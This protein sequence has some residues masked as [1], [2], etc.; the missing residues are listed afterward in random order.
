MESRNKEITQ[1][2]YIEEKAEFTSAFSEVEPEAEVLTE[3]IEQIENESERAEDA[4]DT[5]EKRG[6]FIERIRKSELFTTPFKILLC[7]TLASLIVYVISRFVPTFAE[8]WTRYPAQSIRFV[9]AKLT[10]WIPFSLAETLIVSLPALA[11]AYIVGS[12]V[13]TKRDGSDKNFYRWLRPLLSVV[14]VI[15]T[16]FLS[17]FGPAYGRYTLA[18][19][20][21]LEQKAV[22]SEELF[23]TGIIVSSMANLELREVVFDLSGASV[24]PYDYNTLVDKMN[25]AFGNYAETAD[26]IGHF[27]SNPK[28]IA[29]SEPMTYTHISGV[30]TFMTGESNV[31]TNY[32]DFLI[33]FT[34]AHEMAHQRGIAREDEANF[35]AFLVCISS[36]DA[37]IRYSGYTNMLHY[38]NG[39]LS[40]AD[41]DKYAVLYRNYIPASIQKEFS[42][43]SK[44][45]DK[46]R[47]SVASEVT[48]AVNNSFL[49]SQ[50][51][52]AGTKSYGLVVD[53]AVSYY[54]AK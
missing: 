49:Q 52:Q 50:G 18:E 45:F 19:N 11:I 17:A 25:K 51:Q 48:G 54:K 34:M 36:D 5:E 33:P 23:S 30:Y 46:Y 42:A 26:Y 6:N 20:L 41:S 43:Y 24:M 29:L 4:A 16:L 27:D 3:E 15:L 44:F 9:L 32:P 10:G 40:R 28:P 22:S 39:A 8:L 1:N 12:T 13:S 31:N 38:L 53:L 7:T 2:E 35:V 14:L 47:E 21:D 37:Y